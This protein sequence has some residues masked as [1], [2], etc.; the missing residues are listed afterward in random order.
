MLKWLLLS[1]FSITYFE[2]R[3]G[4]PEEAKMHLFNN[5]LNE[6]AKKRGKL[7]L[8]QQGILY[9]EILHLLRKQPVFKGSKLHFS[10]W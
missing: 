3:R 2:D 8:R 4:M 6:K 1:P 9:T 7:R 10:G 5:R